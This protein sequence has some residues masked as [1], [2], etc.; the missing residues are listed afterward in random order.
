MSLKSTQRRGWKAKPSKAMRTSFEEWLIEETGTDPDSLSSDSIEEI[1]F[2]AGWR[3]RK[4]A[5]YERI[6][7]IKKL[8]P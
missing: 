4:N 7:G 5:E 8:F 1:A 6:Y 3:A 2:Y